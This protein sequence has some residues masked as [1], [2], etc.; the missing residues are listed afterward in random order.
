MLEHCRLMTRYN[1]WMNQRLYAVAARMTDEERRANRGAFFKSIHG[2]LNHILVGDGLWMDRFE[3]L[4]GDWR[5]FDHE[6][7]ADIAGLARARRAMDERIAAYVE[8]LTPAAIAADL[9]YRTA[10]GDARRMPLS[11][12]LSHFFNHQTHH[13]GQVTTLFTQIGID[14]GDT[15]IVAMPADLQAPGA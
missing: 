13:R 12:A 10:S 2:T 3:G 6:A 5:G 9:E 11:R 1:A 15:D 4:P 8:R 7:Q 14:V